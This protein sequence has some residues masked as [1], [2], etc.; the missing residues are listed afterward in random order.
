MTIAPP[1]LA[2]FRFLSIADINRKLNAREFSVSELTEATLHQL[3]TSG[4]SLNAVA[5]IAWDDARRRAARA[6]ARRREGGRSQLLGIP[7]GVKDIFDTAGI[8]TRY[9][10]PPFAGHVPEHD[11][12]VTQRL[13]QVGSVL[14]AKL[15]SMQLAGAGGYRWPSTSLDGA[16]INPWRAGH[17]T[18]GSSSGPAGAVAAGLLPFALGSETT[19]STV[20]PA[21]FCGITGLRPSWGI[22]SQRGMLTVAWSIDKPGIL[23]R[24]ASDCRLILKTIAGADA[25]GGTTLKWSLRPGRGRLYRIGVIAQ[26]LDDVPAVADRFTDALGDLRRAGM[27]LRTVALPPADYQEIVGGL[28]EGETALSQHDLVARRGTVERLLDSSQRAGLRRVVRQPSIRYGR[29]VKA[30]AAAVPG[31]RE[32]FRGVDALVAPTS[33]SEAPPIATDLKH[34]APRRRHF[35]ALGAIAGLPGISVPMGFGD[36]GMPLGLSIMADHLR[37][38]VVLDIAEQFQMSTD[39]HL[40]RPGGSA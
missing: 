18:G 29:A 34:W 19:G 9:G 17:W 22:V 36:H 3:D 37:D 14:I 25:S 26:E 8:P 38:D 33:V 40:A 39:W 30:R 24:A 23:S 10:A 5:E 27:R 7:Y 16:A 12:D 28:L 11:A 6:E 21:A 1:T 2:D 13:R 32:L 20:V 35:G 31:L 15:A 4:R